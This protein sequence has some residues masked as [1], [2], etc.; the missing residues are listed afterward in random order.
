M[1]ARYSDSI[2]LS[3]LNY[4]ESDRI[5][6]L[7]TKDF[8][9]V[10]VI[11]R[12]VRKEKSKLAGGI[13]LFCTC[14]IGFIESRCELAV[15]VSSRL[16]NYYGGFIKQLSRVNFA[17]QALKKVNKITEDSVDASYYLLVK[18]LL[19]SLQKLELSLDVVELWWLVNLLKTT[20]HS[21]NTKS[22]LGGERFADNQFYSFIDNKG[23]FKLSK[24]GFTPNH[25]KLIILAS[26]RYPATLGRVK[27]G[28]RLAA[29][30]LPAIRG[31]VE[32]VL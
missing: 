28:E 25:I 9:K 14:N 10:K 3:R 8:G 7:L 22:L 15:L 26:K 19:E 16:I 23:G 5:L 6:T 2:I 4:G 24:A 17:Y 30:L 21:I 20:G 1:Q 32:Y 29:E 18:K 27:N 31:F 12:G 11:A 13:E